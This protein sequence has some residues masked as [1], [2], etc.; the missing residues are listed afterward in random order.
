MRRLEHVEGDGLLAV[1]TNTRSFVR[2]SPGRA[3]E[4]GPLGVVEVQAGAGHLARVVAQPDLVAEL[5]DDG[6]V[7]LG[8]LPKS[9]PGAVEV[10]VDDPDLTRVVR[11]R[12]QSVEQP[13]P[14][15]L[16]LRVLEEVHGPILTGSVQGVPHVERAEDRPDDWGPETT[17]SLAWDRGYIHTADGLVCRVCGALL[18]FGLRMQRHSGPRPPPRNA[19]R[20]GTDSLRRSGQPVTRL[21][22][23]NGP[24]GVGKSTLATRYAAEHPGTL[25]CDIDVL[26]TMIGG[27]EDDYGRAGGL[28]RPAALGLITAYLRESGDVVLPQ[29]IARATELAKFE[30]AASDAG[31]GFVHVLLLAGPGDVSRAVRGAGHRRATSARGQADRRRGRRSRGRRGLP[32]GARR[33]GRRP[34]G[35]GAGGG[36][37]HRRRDVRRAAGRHR[38]LSP[39]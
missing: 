6:A 10:A 3:L 4:R 30:R 29:L 38:D 23:L 14:L 27:W 18:P 12:R 28:V 19:T 13:A 34:A 21:I 7:R 33:A 15:P 26:R 8:H 17:Q 35:H 37:G 11:E 36:V 22:L 16:D 9:Q 24:P 5:A 2:T 25:R 20:T 39:A 31:A 32:A 1:R